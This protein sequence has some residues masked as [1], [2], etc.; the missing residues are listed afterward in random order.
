[1]NILILGATGFLG[2]AFFLALVNDHKVYAGSR[3]P[4]N[5][6]GNWRHV[7]LL[8]NTDWESVLDG[9]ELVINAVG[10]IEG[11]FQRVQVDAPIAL[12]KVCIL[13]KIKIIHVSAI[14][15]EKVN[16]LSEFLQ[17]KKIADTFL[18]DYEHARIVYPGIVIGR[19]GQSSQFFKEIA[20]LPVIALFSDKPASFVHIEQLT[21]LIRNIVSDFTLYPKQVFAVA[22]PEKLNVIFS[23]LRGKPGFFISVPSFLF[24]LFFI[25]FPYAKIGILNKD[26]FRLFLESEPNDYEPIFEK[27]SLRIVANQFKASSVFTEIFAIL[28]IAFL[29]IWTAIVS[30]I[31]WDH[32]YALMQ[33]I[34]ANHMMSALG[35]WTGAIVDLVL[36]LA[37][38]SKKYRKK[39]IVL[40]MVIVFTYMLILTI[41]SP[42]HWLHPFGV[43][44]KN[45]P[46]IALSY[47]LWKK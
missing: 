34:G 18:L 16:P 5:G 11:D 38:F 14:G 41:F 35:I 32:S 23:A 43:L 27:V 47:Y 40:Q 42:H 8:E 7:D 46:L 20:N 44:S 25:L 4:I 2:E 26:T 13:K 21:G 12:Y 30:L 10:I 39:V 31:A 45:I 24:S 36:G 37:I 29:W 9:I 19:K 33:E 6:Y 1:M 28:A 15:A 22:E 3:K 17:T